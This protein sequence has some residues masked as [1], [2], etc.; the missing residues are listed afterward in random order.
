MPALQV[1]QRALR[2]EVRLQAGAR[3]AMIR[4]PG[5]ELEELVRKSKLEY[6]EWEAKQRSAGCRDRSGNQLKK[7][8]GLLAGAIGTGTVSERWLEMWVDMMRE[9]KKRCVACSEEP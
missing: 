9:H 2:H 4:Q 5:P 3:S 8:P 6:D 7:P 1:Y